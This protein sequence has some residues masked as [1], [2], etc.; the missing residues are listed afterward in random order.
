MFDK[1]YPRQTQPMQIDLAD[2]WFN[3]YMK[4]TWPLIDIPSLIHNIAEFDFYFLS[5]LIFFI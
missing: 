5:F 2:E 3:W 1:T 4:F